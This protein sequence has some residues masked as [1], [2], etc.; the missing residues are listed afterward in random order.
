MDI[1]ILQQINDVDLSK[2]ET[3][4]PL[5]A[6]GIV[7]LNIDKLDWKQEESKKELGKT[8][9]Y[10]LCEFSLAQPWKTAPREGIPSKAINPGDRGS[11]IIER[12]YVGKKV[13]E[14]TG[15]EK[16]YGLDTITKLREAVYGKAAE[17]S[18]FDPNVLLG[19]QLQ[20]ELKFDP[21]PV[22]KETKEV[23]GPRT[24]IKNF[25]RKAK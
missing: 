3:D 2:V 16:W 22:N 23:Y 14:K 7:T 20:A 15:E 18:K 9:T 17:G 5:L 21:A 1:D 13:D 8:N 25:I 12:I 10:L 24:T 6:S 19:Q 11:K 4:F